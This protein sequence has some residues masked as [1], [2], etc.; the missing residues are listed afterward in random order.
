MLIGL[1]PLLTGAL[2]HHLDDMGHGDLVLVADAHF[3]A[4]RVVGRVLDLPGV[5]AADAVEAIRS[6]LPLDTDRPVTFMDPGAVRAPALEELVAACDVAADGAPTLGRHEFYAVA[7][8]AVLAVR[9]GERRVF[10][11]AL[12]RKGVA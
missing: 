6:V 4:S 5:R 1:H 11:N 8:D 9:T 2:L 12:L 3:P 10:G 7:A